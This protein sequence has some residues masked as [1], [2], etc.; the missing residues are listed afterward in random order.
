MGNWKLVASEKD[1]NEL[2]H[3]AKDPSEAFNLANE[4]PKRLKAMLAT[5][6]EARTQD[7]DSV[8]K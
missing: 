6:E 7:N 4:E 3:I 8:V 2:F 5:L 1:R